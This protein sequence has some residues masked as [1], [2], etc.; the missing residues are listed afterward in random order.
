MTFVTR[1]P[2]SLTTKTPPG[3]NECKWKN[4]TIKFLQK[5]IRKTHNH[6]GPYIKIFNKNSM[7]IIK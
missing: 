6:V 1:G 2:L 3:T 5:Q 7:K 4:T